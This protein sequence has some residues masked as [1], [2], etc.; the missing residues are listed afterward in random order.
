L[1][2]YSGFLCAAAAVLLTA[3]A[4]DSATVPAKVTLTGAYATMQGQ[5]LFTFDGDAK[6]VPAGGQWVPLY[7]K[8][9]DRGDHDFTIVDRADGTLQWAFRGKPVYYFNG[10]DSARGRDASYRSGDWHRVSYPYAAGA[11]VSSGGR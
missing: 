2:R 8:A 10:E 5:E 4:G 3:C 7:G 1:S 9:D 6:D 11:G